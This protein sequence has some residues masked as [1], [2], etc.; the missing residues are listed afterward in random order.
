MWST[1]RIKSAAII[2][3]TSKRCNASLKHQTDFVKTSIHN[4]QL[5]CGFFVVKTGNIKQIKKS[6]KTAFL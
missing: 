6:L 1:I 5:S 4:P 3:N 2:K